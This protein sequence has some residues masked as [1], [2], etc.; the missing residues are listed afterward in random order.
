[1]KIRAIEACTCVVPLDSG[2]A[3]ATRALRERHFTLVR[4]QTEEPAKE[5]RLGALTPEAAPRLATVTLLECL[6][7]IIAEAA[8]R[9][10]G[11]L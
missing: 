2:L 3:I 9:A 10:C 4:V 7:T 8:V 6:Q 5:L 1:M 11:R